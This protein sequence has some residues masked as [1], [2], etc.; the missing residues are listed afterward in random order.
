MQKNS[1][2]LRWLLLGEFLGSFGNS[3]IWPLTTIYLH[4]QLHQ[5]LTTSGIVLMLYSGANVLGSAISGTRFDR[6]NPQRMMLG[7]L[8]GAMLVMVILVKSNGW[9]AY[10]LLLTLFG[11]FNG[12]IITLLNAFGTQVTDQSSRYVFRMLYFTNNLGV[13]FGTM[14]AGPLYQT[15][16]NRVAPM[17]AITI[18]L[19]FAYVLVV[20]RHFTPTLTAK[21]TQSAHHQR[22]PIILPTA[23]R[24]LVWTL[25]GAIAIIWVAYAQWSSN[26]SVY[27]TGRGISMAQYSL[28]WTLNGVL[29]LIFQVI[30][31]RLAKFLTND[32]GFL[33]FGIAA[34]GLSFVSL[35][36][37]QNYWGFVL[38]MVTL[39]LGEATAFPTIPAIVNE[40]TPQQFKGRYQGRLNAFT[41]VG[42]ALGPLLGGAM[43]GLT[44]YRDLFLMCTGAI[45][46]VGG[47]LITVRLVFKQAIQ[48]F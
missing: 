43:I 15:T 37:A 27:M 1:L 6:H 34:C 33:Y 21:P 31:N 3:F 11:F 23:N 35:T 42:K 8:G 24:V 12:W 5:S 39:T 30:I 18:C 7:G 17:F 28:L 46:L 47:V 44:S 32:Y 36:L 13:V 48:K 38:G 2:Q 20:R 29:I 22:R 10:P 41:S 26:L 9:P 45:T 19:Y 25:F 40:L 16:G 14:V 4:N